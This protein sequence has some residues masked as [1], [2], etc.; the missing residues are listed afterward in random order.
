[1]YYVIFLTTALSLNPGSTPQG[2][3]ASDCKRPIA[4]DRRNS[5]TANRQTA[6]CGWPFDQYLNWLLDGVC[7]S[8]ALQSDVPRPCIPEVGLHVPSRSRGDKDKQPKHST[9]QLLLPPNFEFGKDLSS[10]TAR[11]QLNLVGGYSDV[12]PVPPQCL[13]SIISGSCRLPLIE[14]KIKTNRQ[15]GI[16]VWYGR[17]K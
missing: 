6:I 3:G 2:L 4:R 14:Q 12:R 10:G 17:A 9:N 16:G 13:P 8:S 5:K 1:M 11:L 15:H 7:K